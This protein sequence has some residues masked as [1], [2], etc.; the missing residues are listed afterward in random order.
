M[1]SVTA[2]NRVWRE[3]TIR[4]EDIVLVRNAIVAAKQNRSCGYYH[5]TSA[6]EKKAARDFQYLQDDG[7]VPQ[8]SQKRSLRLEQ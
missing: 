5:N 1:A 7:L 6:L 3:Y 4:R 2:W 8:R